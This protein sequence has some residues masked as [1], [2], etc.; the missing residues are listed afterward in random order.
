LKKPQEE[1]VKKFDRLL[2]NQPLLKPGALVE[3]GLFGSPT[4]VQ[5]ALKRGDFLYIVQGRHKLISRES[6]LEWLEK[7]VERG[8]RS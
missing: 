3:V 8:V 5:H 6:V 7:A 4:A 1:I 2:P